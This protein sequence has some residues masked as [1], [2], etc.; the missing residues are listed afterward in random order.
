[1]VIHRLVID[2]K[3]QAKAYARKLMDFAEKFANENNYSSIRLDTY[4]QNKRVIDFYEK[5]KYFIRGNVNFP[6]RKYIF[7]CIEK[8]IITSYSKVYN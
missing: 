4:S 6:E 2:P 5:R 3:Y 7:H 8:E 1:M